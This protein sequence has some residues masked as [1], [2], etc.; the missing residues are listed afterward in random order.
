[1]KWKSGLSGLT[2]GDMHILGIIQARM[3]STR[4]PGKVLMDINGKPMLWH[5]VNRLR[6]SRLLG[7][8]IV[9]TTVDSSDDPVADMCR[10]RGLLCF[11]GSVNDVL[12]RYY[13]AALLARADVVVRIT[14]DCPLLDATVVDRVIEV[15]INEKCD[16]VSNVNPP[17]YPDGLDVEIFGL[18]PFCEVWSRAE[19]K[20]E[21]EHVTPYF[22]EHPEMFRQLNVTNTCDLSGMRWTVDE[23]SDLVFVKNVYKEMGCEFFS[24]DEI[25]ELLRKDPSLSRINTGFLRNEGYLK[26]LSRDGKA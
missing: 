19:K 1:M 24:M 6:Q 15:Y 17:T 20:S 8:V 18:Q 13:Q 23:Q 16:Y 26:S 10:V 5:V 11:R 4:L 14:A 9:A 7:Q 2:D 25:V 12:D 21:R 3:G 22:R